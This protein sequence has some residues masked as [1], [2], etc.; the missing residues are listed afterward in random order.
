MKLLTGSLAIALLVSSACHADDDADL[1]KVQG[2]WKIVAMQSGGKDAGADF[3]KGNLVVAKKTFTIV[4]TR[5]G[6]ER[7]LPIQIKLDSSKSPKQIDFID[8]DGKVNNHGIYKL[9]G[10]KLTICFDR[11]RRERPKKFESKKDT[12]V[13]LMVVERKPKKK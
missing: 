5:N 9:D 2:H 13:R 6:T 7:K 8:K 10:K 12:R 4:F 1:K 11:V 3:L